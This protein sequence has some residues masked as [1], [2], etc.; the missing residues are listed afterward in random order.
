MSTDEDR[1][2]EEL[3][4]IA[5]AERIAVLDSWRPAQSRIASFLERGLTGA[6]SNSLKDRLQ[7]VVAGLTR[8][9]HRPVY[10]CISVASSH[11][12]GS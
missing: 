2:Y 4:S 1:A 5:P 8:P 11:E 9:R 6:N 10:Q 12:L 3:V 7:L